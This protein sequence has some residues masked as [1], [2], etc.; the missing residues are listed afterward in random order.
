MYWLIIHQSS[1]LADN[2]TI[3]QPERLKWSTHGLSFTLKP[4]SNFC[5][6]SHQATSV[7]KAIKQLLLLK[8]WSNFCCS[9]HQAIS[10][11]GF[12]FF[13]MLTFYYQG[14]LLVLSDFDCMLSV[15]AICFEDRLQYGVWCSW[16]L[17]WLASCRTALVNHSR[18]I[19][20]FSFWKWLKI[21]AGGCRINNH[22]CKK[23]QQNAIAYV[24]TWPSFYCVFQML[25]QQYSVWKQHI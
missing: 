4:S 18:E 20:C 10:V 13:H 5:C 23:K 21:S 24:K 1:L 25:L 14:H 19:S 22:N 6:S 7:A 11:V 16:E 2:V 12:F 9:S 8:P 3:V 15:G 17:P